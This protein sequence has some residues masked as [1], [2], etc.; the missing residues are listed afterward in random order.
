MPIDPLVTIEGRLDEILDCDRL[1]EID[2]RF[3]VTQGGK[4]YL[5]RALALRCLKY[6]LA[7]WR[8]QLRASQT[9]T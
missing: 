9:R 1:D 7:F 2:P 4:V 6:E 8:E 5:N 3:I